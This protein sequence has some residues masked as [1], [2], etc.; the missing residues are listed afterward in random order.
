MFGLGLG[1]EHPVYDLFS[2]CL[3]VFRKPGAWYIR[4]ADLPA[5]LRRIAPALEKRLACSAL[6][7]YTGRLKISFY[8]SGIALSLAEAVW[9]RSKRGRQPRRNGAMPPSPI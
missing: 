7:G 5:F 3:P 9:R 8:R 6:A 2:D 1:A 4:V